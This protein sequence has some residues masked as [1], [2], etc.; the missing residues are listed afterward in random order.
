MPSHDQHKIMTAVL[1]KANTNTINYESYDENS[2]RHIIR[3]H[4]NSKKVVIKKV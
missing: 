1:K 3:G 2:D 4:I